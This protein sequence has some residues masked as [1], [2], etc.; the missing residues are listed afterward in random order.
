M[1]KELSTQAK[2]CLE[3]WQKEIN[4]T[5]MSSLL[6]GGEVAQ[7]LLKFGYVEKSPFGVFQCITC[8]E[9]GKIICKCK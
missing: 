6:Q 2:K 3:Q 8:G 9:C 5:G 1:R 7:E 4:D